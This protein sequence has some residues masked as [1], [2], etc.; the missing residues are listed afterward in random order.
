[1]PCKFMI[2]RYTVTKLR[3][4][5]E[6]H[7]HY[8]STLSDS[9]VIHATVLKR[10]NLKRFVGKRFNLKRFAGKRFVGK[11]FNLKRFAGKRF[12]LK[13]FVGKRFNLKRFAGKRFAGKRFNLKQ[14]D[15]F[16]SDSLISFATG[17]RFINRIAIF[18]ESNSTAGNLTA[19]Y[20]ILNG[21]FVPGTAQITRALF[22]V[23]PRADGCIYM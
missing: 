19:S 23:Y 4:P 20:N 7:T 16:V 5:R 22:T 6:T 13:R 9:I 3:W 1:M 8:D 12:N 2:I 18:L 21:G 10:F 14:F 17:K 15:F 11:R